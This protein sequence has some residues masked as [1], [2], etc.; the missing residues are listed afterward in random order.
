MVHHAQCSYYEVLLRA[1]VRIWLY[2]APAVLH[3][4]HLSV[5]GQ[6]AVIG[7]SNMDI[8]SFNLNLEVTVM[9]RGAAFVDALREVQDDY[10]A[11][12]RELTVQEWAH[13]PIG[14]RM[15]DGVARLTSALQ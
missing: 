6:V 4:K 14:A 15:L 8:R 7:S 1:G 5:D 11:R 3:A 2:P 10:R 9:V 13:R 12:S